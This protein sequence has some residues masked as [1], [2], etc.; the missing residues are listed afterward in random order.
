MAKTKNADRPRKP[1]KAPTPDPVYDPWFY[2]RSIFDDLKSLVPI[3][4]WEKKKRDGDPHS[5]E[6]NNACAGAL[7]LFFASCLVY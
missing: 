5:L 4:P 2:L 6:R 7:A 3:E 1:T